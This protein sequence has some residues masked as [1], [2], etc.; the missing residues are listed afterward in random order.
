MA[1][2]L[3]TE[4]ERPIL[5]RWLKQQSSYTMWRQTG[6]YFDAWVDEAKRISLLAFDAAGEPELNDSEMRILL[7]CRAAFEDALAKLKRGDR[8]AFK[9]LG[10]GTGQGYFCEAGRA[11]KAWNTAFGRIQE[12]IPLGGTEYMPA[13]KQ[14]F[15]ALVDVWSNGGAS[16]EP[17][18]T[19]VPAVV[20]DMRDLRGEFGGGYPGYRAV[21]DAGL[22]LPPVPTPVEEVIIK[23]G[24]SIPCYGIWEPVKLDMTPGFVGLFKKPLIPA[25]RKFELDG[26]MNYL[27]AGSPAPTIAFEEDD[28]RREGRRTVWRLLWK[29]ER[30]LDGTIPEEEAE[31]VFVGPDPS[32]PVSAPDTFVADDL[33]VAKS[34][35][36][37]PRAGVWAA[38]EILHVRV[39]MARS[40]PLPQHDSHDIEWVYVSAA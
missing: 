35:T 27:H 16:L 33:I 32:E 5:F 19:D 40:A 2:A 25:D 34:G 7:S 28:N 15:D 26:C 20:E 39:T 13:F 31:Y 10:W 36:P 4:E 37:A 12:G 6:P 23:T 3:P 1:Y 14:R 38:K 8:S 17:R 9:W 18:H 24:D 21:R 29:D 30:Y 22:V 11:I